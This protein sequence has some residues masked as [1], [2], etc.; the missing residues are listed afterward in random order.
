MKLKVRRADN[1]GNRIFVEGNNAAA[2]GAVYGGATVCAWYPIT[3]S[4]SLAEAFQSHCK[5]LRHDKETGKA[6]YA[7]VQAEDE[8]ASIGIVIGAG[9]NGARA[10]TCD[11]GSGH[12]AD[13]RVHRARLL[14]RGAG[15]DGQRAARRSVDRHADAHP[16]VRPAVP[17]PTPPT[18][19]P[20]TCCC[21]PRIPKEC[22]DFTADA[23][24]LADRLQT[25]VF[26]MTDLDIGMNHRLCEPFQ[27]DEKR[28]LDRG[29]VMT[30]ADL[31]AGKTF[32][33]YLD[34]DGDGIPFRTYPGTHPTKGSYF[35]RGTTKD[36]YA[37]YSEEG[38]GLC[39]QHGAAAEEVRRRPR[40]SRRSRCARPRRKATRYGVIYFGS[41][42]PA[43]AEALDHLEADGHHVNALRVR[44]F[45]FA[46]RRS[47]TSSTS[48]TRC[49]SS[50]R[51]ATRSCAPC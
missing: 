10:F 9:W 5:R 22:F 41:T 44:A 2:L 31:E 3:P 14:R 7:I 39:A 38:A 11:V 15:G 42:S 27:W 12:L 37:R 28:D 43:M 46:T 6:K 18:A 21:S 51:T 33:R 34:V 24:D 32:G 40:R 19:T 50:S 13:D 45:P 49:S 25:P 4:S 29:K 30:A 47:R 16:A 26:V 1:V 17:A 23:L 48:T 8:L 35:T 36:E 20:S